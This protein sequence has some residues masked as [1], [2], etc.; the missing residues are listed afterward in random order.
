MSGFSEEIKLFVDRCQKNRLRGVCSKIQ[1]KEV[2]ERLMTYVSIPYIVEEY[3]GCETKQLPSGGFTFHPIYNPEYPKF[4]EFPEA[5]KVDDILRRYRIF[6]KIALE[7]EPSDLV[8]CDEEIDFWKA[9]LEG[10]CRTE[11]ERTFATRVLGRLEHQRKNFT[12]PFSWHLSEDGHFAY[13]INGQTFV[14]VGPALLCST[15]L[16]TMGYCDT[17]FAGERADEWDESKDEEDRDTEHGRCYGQAARFIKTLSP[18]L[19]LSPDGRECTVQWTAFGWEDTYALYPEGENTNGWAYRTKTERVVVAPIAIPEVSDGEVLRW[20]MKDGHVLSL[21]D[22]PIFDY[23]QLD[24]ARG[25]RDFIERSE[26][27]VRT[28]EDGQFLAVFMNRMYHADIWKV[29]RERRC[30][31]YLYTLRR[32]NY[33]TM[34]SGM[35]LEFVIRKSDGKTVLVFHAHHGQLDVL[36]PE[37]GDTLHTSANDDRF[38]VTYKRDGMSRF[39]MDCWWWGPSEENDLSVDIQELVTVPN[40]KL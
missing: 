2:V 25:D 22:V 6:H 13:T 9:V 7:I 34:G 29:D 12:E 24:E 1:N 17:N 3:L 21:N 14:N 38:I 4:P 5:S 20:S 32:S 19:N 30:I 18:L 8:S 28:S 36:D 37:S 15:T 40:T 33:R 39:V 23:I 26:L 16:D 31:Q 35:F 10:D 11:N 27:T